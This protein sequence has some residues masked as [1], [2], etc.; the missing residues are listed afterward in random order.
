VKG[1]FIDKSQN[2]SSA[3]LLNLHIKIIHINNNGLANPFK[4]RGYPHL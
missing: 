2:P 1:F 4:K 3:C